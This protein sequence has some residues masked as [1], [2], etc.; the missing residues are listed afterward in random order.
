M[1]SAS[2]NHTNLVDTLVPC[3]H[4]DRTYVAGLENLNHVLPLS[5]TDRSHFRFHEMPQTGP[6]AQRRGPPGTPL[7]CA[8]H[9]R[10][11]SRSEFTG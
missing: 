3:G 9:D 10:S 4:E 5:G 7:T 8:H 1:C 6:H 11:T 2:T